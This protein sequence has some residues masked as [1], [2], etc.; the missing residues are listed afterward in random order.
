M[1][2]AGRLCAIVFLSTGLMGPGH[3]F[4]QTPVIPLSGKIEEQASSQ[5]EAARKLKDT[6]KLE[7][8]IEALQQLIADAPQSAQVPE[9]YWLLGQFLTELKKPD[10]AGPYFRRL[11]EEYP[12]SDLAPQARL[13]LASALLETGQPDAALPL[14]LEARAQTTDQAVLL[15][16][17]QHL[18]ETYLNK[19]DHVRAVEAA[20]EAAR[21]SSEEERKKIEA[22]VRDLLQS[23]L[24]EKDLRRI[25]DKYG[26]SFPADAALLRLI[27]L[28]EASGEDHKVSRAAREFL[29]QFSHH[30]KAGA[31]TTTLTAQRKKLR[32]KTHRIGA[33]LPLSGQLSPYGTDALNGARIALEVVAE[34]SPSLSVGLVTKDTEGDAKLLARELDD[35]L[36]DYQPIAVI[37]PLLSR[38]VK[39]VAQAAD[40]NEVVFVTPT[41]TVTDVQKFGRYLF[42]AAVNNRALVRELAAY[43][44]GPLGWKRFCILA[45]KD[46][47]GT[48]MAQTFAEE[49]RRL[50]GELI[51]SE[52][53]GPDDTDLGPPIKR[54]K[55]ADL[56]KHGKL[57]KIENP[58]KGK[59]DKI[60][61]PGFDAIFLPG[62]AEKVGLIAGQFRFYAASVGMLGT[63][64]MNS[65]EL[66]RL[67]PRGVEGAVFAD[68]FSM[69]SP[70]PAVRN[71]VERYVKRFQ[72]PPS[73]FAAQAFEATKLVLDAILKGAT[74]GRALRESLKNTKNAPGLVGPLT[75]TAAGNL[76]RRYA[77]SQVKNGKFTSVTDAR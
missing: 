50:G 46:A 14:L 33:L 55:D 62:D 34:A 64:G 27:E 3:T 56:R 67:D 15:T 51:A 9:A 29:G 6:G 16:I 49:I 36:K 13:A 59:S 38:E 8:A 47:Y 5:M 2:S 63:N 39:A 74:T 72:Q 12:E 44:T 19:Q 22:R 57:E 20:V 32:S 43:A 26:K 30:E 77:I 69:D 40:A 58:K 73:G 54:L 7:P 76:E 52:T 37:G 1:R 21:L 31:V 11:L 17:H 53:Y 61:H 18:E 60:Y 4:A 42:N 35:L 45:A 66:V 71:F 48:E 25:A 68:S 65:P 28:Y 23:T 70:D 24:G 10:E 75:M 41:A